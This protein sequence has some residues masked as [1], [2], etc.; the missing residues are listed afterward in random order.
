MRR[1][2]CSFSPPPALSQ[3]ALA[4]CFTGFAVPARHYPSPLIPSVRGIDSSRAGGT[5]VSQ[6]S[7]GTYGAPVPTIPS[8]LNRSIV[9]LH[10]NHELQDM[11]EESCPQPT[12]ASPQL[13]VRPYRVHG[14]VL[15]TFDG[16]AQFSKGQSDA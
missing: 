12:P 8:H 3:A 14:P 7:T 6:T 2:D 13:S 5:C 10:E 16:R 9:S 15:N 1:M 11:R 4:R